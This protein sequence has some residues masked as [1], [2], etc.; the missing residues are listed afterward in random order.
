MV[1]TLKPPPIFVVDPVNPA[2]IV[3]V[4]VSGYLNK[5]IPEPPVPPEYPLGKSP[6]PAPPPPPRFVVPLVPLVFAVA[7]AFPP[8]PVPPKPRLFY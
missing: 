1:V 4:S 6:E 7:L 3:I 2:P 5:T 8:P